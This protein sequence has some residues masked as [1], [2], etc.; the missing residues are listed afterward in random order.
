M[1]KVAIVY[2]SG[3]GHTKL[4]AE[5]VHRGAA[6]VAGVKAVLLTT[7]E[8]GADL[9]SLDD[10]DGI[11]FGTPT[12]MGSM[13]AEMKKFLEAAAAKWFTQAW[14][15]KVAGAFTNSS[16]YSGDKLNTLVGLM[17]NAMQQGMIYVSLGMQPAASDPDSMNRIQGPGPEVM[18]RIGSY[19]GPMAASFQVDPGD[20]P[21][22][23]DI[24]TA[25]AY[26]VRV[27]TITQQ[28]VRGKE[29]A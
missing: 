27:A 28:L 5:A 12:Y 24:A 29:A 14:K 4:Q 17:I 11:I 16:S 19:M 8:A 10:A 20:A 21:S 26:G 13:S 1:I 7:Q 23:G 2:H 15:D 22:T 6:S 3:F 18:N 25:E 9:D